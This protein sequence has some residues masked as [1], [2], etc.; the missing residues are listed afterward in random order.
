MAS[1]QDKETTICSCVETQD[2]KATI[3]ELE[4]WEKRIEIEKKAI[5]G[6]INNYAG[7]IQRMSDEKL[8]VEDEKLSEMLESEGGAHDTIE[9]SEETLLA[10]QL[11]S[12]NL[13][14]RIAG[15][16]T[17]PNL[18]TPAINPRDNTPV[19]NGNAASDEGRESEERNWPRS[20]P[21][22]TDGGRESE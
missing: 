1:F 6:S 22:N 15:A 18:N 5:N 4:E 3:A 19:S 17:T 9:H 14:G 21:P 7:F 10:I 16:T 11:L 20:Q 12:C 13:N 2:I 8:A